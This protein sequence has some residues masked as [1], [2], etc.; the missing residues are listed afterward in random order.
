MMLSKEQIEEIRKMSYPLVSYLK[1]FSPHV[2][3]T[4]D[5]LNVEVWEGTAL[6][7]ET[8]E[9]IQTPERESER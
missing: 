1:N 3:I 7:K 6:I 8:P 5:S 4:I 9:K 2:M